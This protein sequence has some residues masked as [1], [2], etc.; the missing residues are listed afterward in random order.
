[1]AIT[2]S[3]IEK[4]IFMASNYKAQNIPLSYATGNIVKL[5]KL[6]DLNKS[7]RVMTELAK[8]QPSEET[9][10]QIIHG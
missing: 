10:K 3:R 9:I 6:R 5:L 8:D 2:T 1:M 4:A 7:A